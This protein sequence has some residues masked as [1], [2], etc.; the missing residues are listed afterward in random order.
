[1]STF[2]RAMTALLLSAFIT[3]GT[4]AMAQDKGKDAKGTG[5]KGEAKVKVYYENDA[6]RVFDVTYKPGDGGPSVERPLRIIRVVKGGTLTLT[7]PDGKKDKLPWK[8]GEVRVRE[9]TPAYAVSNQGK[10]DIQ[11]YVVYVKGA[12]KK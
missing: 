12:T 1:M 10:S 5:K 11:L 6:V 4:S 8:T 9:A 3:V 2:I 7:Y